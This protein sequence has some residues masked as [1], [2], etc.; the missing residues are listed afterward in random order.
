MKLDSID[1]VQLQALIDR[2]VQRDVIHPSSPPVWDIKGT[3]LGKKF[4]EHLKK[5]S[6]A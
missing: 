5:E 3:A 1:A 2:L 4:E 6:K